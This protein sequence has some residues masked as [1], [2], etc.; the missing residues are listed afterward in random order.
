MRIPL[1]WVKD[2]VN[3]DK[4]KFQ[5]LI[6]ALNKIGF[7]VDEI[8]DMSKGLDKVFVCQIL[9][10]KKH[11]N[12]DKLDVCQCD[13]GGLGKKQ[14][15]T[16][17]KNIKVGDF[18][19]V[20][21]DGAS[22]PCGKIITESQ[23]RG[24]VSQGMFC[25]A[26]E[27]G[28][29]E[30]EF[31][32]ADNDGLLVLNKI[33]PKAGTKIADA[34]NRNDIVL[35]ISFLPN[36]ADAACVAGVA[37]EIAAYFGL[38][39]VE[40]D[41]KF[42]TKNIK[43]PIAVKV[44]DNINCE[45]YMGAYIESVKNGQSP[46]W[47][48]RRLVMAG[49]KPYSILV[50]ITNYVLTEIGQPMHAFDVSKIGG[51][52]LIVRGAKK[53]EKI[54]T[55]DNK[56][57]TLEKGM[58]VIAD[59]SKPLAIAGIMGGIDSG[60][61]KDTT[62][63]FLESASFAYANVRKTA[64]KL[65]VSTSSSQRFGKTLS[66]CSAERGL[67][68][69]L[70]LIDKLGLGQISSTI[71]DT[72]K[73]SLSKRTVVASVAN[74]NQRLSLNVS[75]QQMG[76]I[77]SSLGFEVTIKG[78]V[79]SAVVPTWRVDVIVEADLSEEIGRTLGYDNL[80]ENK[81]SESSSVFQGSYENSQIISNQIKNTLSTMGANEVLS[82]QFISPDSAVKFGL[83]TD[84]CVQILNPLGK[85][86]SLL[87]PNL[88]VNIL[89]IISYNLRQKNNNLFLFEVARVF[90]KTKTK[91]NESQNLCIVMQTED[92]YKVKSILNKV[93]SVFSVAPVFEA[94]FLPSYLHPGIS[95]N[96]FVDNKRIGHIGQLHP[97][98]AKDFGIDTKCVVAEISL[99]SLF[100]FS[101]KRVVAKQVSKLPRVERDLAFT[102]DKRMSAVE[103]IN[104][105][106]DSGG[107]NIKNICIFDVYEGAQVEE[108]KKSVAVRFYIEQGGNTLNDK[109]LGSILET[110]I[111]G[112]KNRIGAKLR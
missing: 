4:I 14:I 91:P 17:A 59:A 57:Q 69:A 46:D 109:E 67:K 70:F 32:G 103:I 90:E 85:E 27:I 9:D 8:I 11:P 41:T 60:T 35:D 58:L 3:L 75:G 40:P 47:M 63:V 111:N 56:A 48:K 33:N 82:L 1:S 77:L 24:E 65:G 78:D 106:K 12:A 108:G 25:G 74:I 94:S 95:A 83:K 72:N 68:R 89:H 112:C 13:I 62:S 10:I 6:D 22:L 19:P 16:G 2:F 18:V 84:N 92:F 26:D 76:K 29:T 15:V 43:N 96:V 105:V 88:L 44:E 52:Q 5:D 39:F 110:I 37:R 86:Y 104:A 30:D 100:A 97:T 93:L 38:S 101:E 79:L 36:R 23:M 21:L 73:A 81:T 53:D 34:L 42:S 71:V 20:A 54:I 45:R 49:H 107:E 55:L 102:V 66:T 51:G 50:D 80:N 61:Y 98:V 7:V 99:D 31:E 28:I 87:R 64:K